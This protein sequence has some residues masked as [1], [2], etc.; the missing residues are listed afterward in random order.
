M[1]RYVTYSVS[2]PA[3]GV[4]LHHDGHAAGRGPADLQRADQTSGGGG[5]SSAGSR[6]GF[7][8]M[9]KHTT[10]STPVKDAV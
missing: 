6:V 8:D 3:R 2:R 1:T 7:T 4:L 9:H 10:T 5:G